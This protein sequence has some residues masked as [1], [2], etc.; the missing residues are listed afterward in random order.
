MPSQNKNFETFENQNE[1]NFNFEDFGNDQNQGLPLARTIDHMWIKNK[2]QPDQQ[3]TISNEEFKQNLKEIFERWIRTSDEDYFIVD[4]PVNDVSDE[5]K[6]LINYE[7]HRDDYYLHG[8]KFRIV[9]NGDVHVM[10]W[11]KVWDQYFVSED[12]ITEIKSELAEN[13]YYD[14]CTGMLIDYDDSDDY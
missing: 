6:D 14:S 1:E 5:M 9:R 12:C 2:L 4:F 3:P 13:S 10:E 7:E 8:I 11:S